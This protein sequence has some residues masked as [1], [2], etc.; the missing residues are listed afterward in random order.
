VTNERSAARPLGLTLA[1]LG[2]V[3]GDIG[4]SP[5]YAVRESLGEAYDIAATRPNVFGVLSLVFWALVLVIAVKYVLFVLRADNQGEGGILALTALIS[6][7]RGHLE[8]GRRRGLILLG[9]F[10]TALLYGD[11]AITPA[12]SVLAAVEGLEVA[13]PLFE[14]YV[15]PIAIAI[16]VGLFAVQRKGSGAVGAVF[17]PVMVVWFAVL[18]A[19]GGMQI[20]R[21]PSV[22]E[23]VN[24]AY[25]AAFFL[26][27][28][29]PAFL[30]LGSV[31]LVVTGGEALYA[32]MGHF[33][34]GPIRIGWF[35]I[36]M[37]ALL[38]N[39]FGQ[40]AL[41]LSVPGAAESPFFLLAPG[42]ALLPLVA[43]ATAA[44]I[45]ASQA[46]ITGAFS[47]TMQAIHLDYS[48]RMNVLQTSA[49][50]R[51]QIYLGA[52]N[53]ALLATCIG[54]VVGFRRSTNLAAAYGV[55]VTSTMVVTTLL[56][57]IV[58]RHRFAWP[59]W[60]VA[61]LTAVFLGIDLAFFGANLFK[62]PNGGWFPLVAGLV[63]FTVLTTWRHGRG[64]LYQRTRRGDVP[65]DEFVANLASRPV[66]RVPGTGVYMFP[67][68]Q[69][70]PPSLV[71]NLRH[72]HVLHEAVVLLSVNTATTPRVPRARRTTVRDL[73]IG[74]W[75][76]TLTY[77][78][79]ETPDVPRDLEA[80]IEAPSFERAHTTYFISRET[81]RSTVEQSD[82]ARWREHLFA[83]LHRNAS[84]AADH[85]RLPPSRVVEIGTPVEI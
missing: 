21:A 65:V 58:M 14:P 79:A 84:S 28:G 83:L 63:V 27:N 74:F 2:V 55:A 33:G 50:Q 52:V 32:D 70:V 56:F 54:L 51:G 81:V 9:L 67:D 61:L 77:G 68:P 60:L 8:S 62:I 43:L 40:G 82:M 26:E 31:F 29:I 6:G 80:M 44:T 34:V 11:G 39:Y 45:I 69:H 47:L 1:A 48:P 15:I 20:I 76:M 53:W 17:G 71:A 16:L 24:P 72:N 57:A 78:F 30:A 13:T 25:A 4:T 49:T 18:A 42:W 3:Y 23:A 75:Q 5:L 64:L 7:P 41:I 38:L 12:I 19:L 36:V 59:R 37:P 46:L 73:G 10:G 66:P 35:T 22:L 85:F